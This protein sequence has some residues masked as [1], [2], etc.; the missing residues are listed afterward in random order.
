MLRPYG[1]AMTQPGGRAAVVIVGDASKL[2]SQLE[3]DAQA[4]IDG[5]DLNTENIS[6]Q[7]GDAFQEGAREAEKAL[8]DVDRSAAVT[9]KKIVKH[10]DDAQREIER[11]FTTIAKDGKVTTTVVE[12]SFDDA[13]DEIERT[14][15]FVAA[16][17]AES[18]ALIALV[19][20]EAADSVA[21]KWERAG[22]RIEKAFAEARREAV[23]DQV[24]MAAAATATAAAVGKE[25]GTISK[26]FNKVGEGIASAAVALGELGLADTNPVGLVAGLVAFAGA[27]AAVVVLAGSAGAAAAMRWGRA[28]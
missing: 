23:V 16:D 14:F 19:N 26:I 24:E 28:F 25:G 10:I 4:A 8:G 7:I 9:S 15:K 20:R 17:V 5:V 18:A 1:C 13:G 6:D 27:A 2:G 11:S 12:K 3:R 22:E 21:D